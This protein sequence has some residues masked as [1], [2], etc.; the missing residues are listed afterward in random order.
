MVTDPVTDPVRNRDVHR[1]TLWRGND[2]R[3]Y[4]GRATVFQHCD[5]TPTARGVMPPLGFHR[6]CGLRVALTIRTQS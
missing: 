6:I 4:R 1:D 5:P 3:V 2:H